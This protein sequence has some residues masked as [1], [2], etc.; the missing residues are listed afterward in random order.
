MCTDPGVLV[1]LGGTLNLLLTPSARS[2]LIDGV[3]TMPHTGHCWGSDEAGQATDLLFY[4]HQ[5][6]S[7][8][9]EHTGL[10]PPSKT[11]H[12]AL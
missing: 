8:Q 9:D 3:G 4:P 10:D 1:A 7:A 11:R 5:G 2:F 12:T 6:A